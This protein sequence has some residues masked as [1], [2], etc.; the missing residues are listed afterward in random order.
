MYFHF[1]AGGFLPSKKIYFFSCGH[2]FAESLS[3]LFFTGL[4]SLAF[5]N[6]FFA[7]YILSVLRRA[8]FRKSVRACVI[9]LPVAFPRIPVCILHNTFRNILKCSVKIPLKVRLIFR[10][11]E[12][13]LWS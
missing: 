8:A 11:N 5:R 13:F 12:L 10:K 3:L 1:S 7:G 4:L 2:I 6:A 9:P